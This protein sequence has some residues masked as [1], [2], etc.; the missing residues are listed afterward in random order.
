MT[1]P[2]SSPRDGAVIATALLLGPVIGTLI[3][4]VA[5]MVM[6]AQAIL[7]TGDRGELLYLP[8]GA[9][10]LLTFGTVFGLLIGA[11]PAALAGLLYAALRRSLGENGATA[12]LAAFVVSLPLAVWFG[13][14][15]AGHR[16][17]LLV[18][19]H[20]SLSGF[21]TW[22]LATARWRRKARA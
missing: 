21:L 12:T 15:G 2:A 9:V 6:S 18:I 8:L 1:L 10:M 17:A 14:G 7:A 19:A 22:F 13:A 11:I 3:V 5:T 20:V 16:G 4:V